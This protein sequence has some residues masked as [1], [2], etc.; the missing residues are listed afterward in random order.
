MDDDHPSGGKESTRLSTGSALKTIISY[1][2]KAER[3]S[4]CG[5]C[6]LHTY[7]PSAFPSLGMSLWG[8]PVLWRNNKRDAKKFMLALANI[9]CL[10]WPNRTVDLTS[11]TPGCTSCVVIGKILLTNLDVNPGRSLSMMSMI[12]WGKKMC[13]WMMCRWDT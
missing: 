6:R 13:R 1:S 7:I 2:S 9:A 4:P 8:P 5:A 10:F 11:W 3:I 12:E